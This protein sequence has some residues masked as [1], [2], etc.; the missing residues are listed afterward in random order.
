MAS[1]D[2]SITSAVNVTACSDTASGQIRVYQMGNTTPIFKSPCFTGC[3]TES[4][5]LSSFVNGA[6]Y[7]VYV[8]YCETYTAIVPGKTFV[9]HSTHKECDP[10]T[11]YCNDVTGPGTDQCDAVGQLCPSYNL[12]VSNVCKKIYGKGTGDCTAIEQPCNV[13]AKTYHCANNQCVDTPP[14]TVNNTTCFSD[15]GCNQKC[16]AAAKTYR[17]NTT[18]NLCE[19]AACTVDNTTCFSDSKCGGKCTATTNG[20]S[21][22]QVCKRNEDCVA[23]NKGDFCL[24]SSCYK[25][26]DIIMVVGGLF[27]LMMLMRR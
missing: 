16:V 10:S 21:T 9:F 25:K 20:G 26:T 7:G 24:M 2:Y 1:I 12:C 19:D 4:Y 14:C 13:A 18:T 5:P 22:S 23:W 8:V 6:E 17:C 15:P 11:H 3:H 27:V